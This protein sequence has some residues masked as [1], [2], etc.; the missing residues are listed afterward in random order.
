[1]K[2]KSVRTRGKLRFSTYF[3][4]LKNG[5]KVAIIAEG[6]QKVNFPARM[7]GKTGTVDSKRGRSYVIKAKDNNKE[8]QFIIAPIHLKKIKT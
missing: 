3:Q 6:S 8:K 2:S 1:M 4:K 5:E 7:Q